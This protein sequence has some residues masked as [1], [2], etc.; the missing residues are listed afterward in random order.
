VQA[1]IAAGEIAEDRLRRWRKLLR[2]DR[3]NAETLARAQQRQR[4]FGKR[5]RRALQA[6]EHR[7]RGA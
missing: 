6:K 2:E 4:S 3:R 5:A 1:A 7:R